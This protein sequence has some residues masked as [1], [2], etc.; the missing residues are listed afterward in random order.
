M[1]IKIVKGPKENLWVF[2]TELSIY[3]T[4]YLKPPQKTYCIYIFFPHTYGEVKS[5]S[6]GEERRHSLRQTE[7]VATESSPVKQ[8]TTLKIFGTERKK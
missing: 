2:I 7:N 5:S 8:Q 4:I 3:F 1:L 6:I